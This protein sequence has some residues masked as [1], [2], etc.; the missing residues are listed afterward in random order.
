MANYAAE[1]NG[2]Q[3]DLVTTS[4]E[5]AGIMVLASIQ[6]SQMISVETVWRQ[7]FKK[8][9]KSVN[10]QH[11][12]YSQAPGSIAV[13]LYIATCPICPSAAHRLRQG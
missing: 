9:K 6:F 11:A 10:R 1:A 4:A 8:C 13:V 7:P 5:S 2:E 12:G 3:I